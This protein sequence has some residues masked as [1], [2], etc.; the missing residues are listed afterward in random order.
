M[1]PG[2][3]RPPAA[4]S[5]LRG[6]R[7]GGGGS[8]AASASAAPAWASTTGEAVVGNFGGERFFDYTA[9]GDTCERRLAARGAKHAHGDGGAPSAP[10][11]RWQAAGRPSAPSAAAGEGP[12]PARRDIRACRSAPDPPYET[13]YE[14]SPPL[15]RGACP[16]RGPPPRCARSTAARA[17]PPRSACAR[18][19]RRRHRHALTN[20]PDGAEARLGRLPNGFAPV[21]RGE[22]SQPSAEKK[23]R[24]DRRGF[25]GGRPRSFPARAPWRGPA[26]VTFAGAIDM[27]SSCGKKE[28]G[29]VMVGTKGAACAALGNQA[30]GLQALANDMSAAFPVAGPSEAGAKACPCGRRRKCGRSSDLSFWP[31]PPGLALVCR[32]LWRPLC[33]VSPSRR[34]RAMRS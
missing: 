2:R 21:A 19:P 25:R 3:R 16:L 4:N 11:V 15:S 30:L 34:W 20:T 26:P 9:V 31:S 29:C 23:A 8:R 10:R 28:A 5:R 17:P 27:P 13:A 22:A 33:Q 7:S 12:H 6:G 1:P 24:R 18:A 14:R 32:A